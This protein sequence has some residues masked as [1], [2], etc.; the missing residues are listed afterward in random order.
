MFE[1]FQ[2]FEMMKKKKTPLMFEVFQ[3]FE[4][5]K[6]KETPPVFEMFEM[7]QMFQMFWTFNLKKV[8]INWCL[9]NYGYVILGSILSF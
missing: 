4:M 6:K 7:F 3:T 5:M 9:L 1:M 2:T 8:Y